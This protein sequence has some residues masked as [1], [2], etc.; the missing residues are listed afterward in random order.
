MNFTRCVVLGILLV[1]CNSTPK[2]QEGQQPSSVEWDPFLDTLQ[3][4]TFN[5][6]WETTSP[7]NGLTPDR[8]PNLTFSSIA[9]VGFAL[10]AYPIGV[11]REFIT[12]EEATERVLTTLKF[13]WNSPQNDD[14]VKT[15]GYKGFYYH[16]LH[17]DTGLRFRDVELSTIDSGLLFAGMLFCQSYFDRETDAEQ[18]IRAYADSIYRR[19][20]WNWFQVDKPV[21]N[22]GW[23]PE[24]GYVRADWR[25]YNEAMILYFLALGSPT[26]PVEPE[27]WDKWTEPYEWGEYYGYEHVNFGPLFGHQYS[28]CWVDF[29]GIQD[30]YMRKK[31]ID[32]FENSRRA[33]YSQREY[34]MA[35]PSKFKDYSGDIWGLTACDGPRDTTFT[36]DGTSR[37]FHTYWA[38]G[39]AI[40]YTNDDGTLAPTALGGSLAFAPEICILALKAIRDKYGS[41]VW[42]DYGFIDAFNP[43]FVTEKTGPA[44]WFDNDYLGIDQG[45]I[46]I[47]I[48]NLRSEFVWNT[49]KKNPYV[50]N[51]LKRAGFSGGWLDATEAK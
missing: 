8:Y 3:Q 42:R 20:D 24:R 33:T 23:R 5:W 51:G 38:R 10:T 6:F 40:N 46:I 16:F 19:A 7:K 25:G 44:G 12:R 43:T 32:Y 36:V 1:A 35:N 2:P 41:N 37:R 4:R 29:R 45:P 27:V 17:L 21:V 11:E 48:E 50:V 39:A 15:T 26:H 18:Q 13:F 49:M 28:H 34:A 30:A 14:P 47:M 31:G 22:M 9:A